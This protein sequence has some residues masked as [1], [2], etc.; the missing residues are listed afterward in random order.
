MFSCAEAVWHTSNFFACHAMLFPNV[1]I[2][3]TVFFLPLQNSFQP[4]LLPGPQHKSACYDHFTC[5]WVDSKVAISLISNLMASSLLLASMTSLIFQMFIRC[6]K[7]W[8]LTILNMIVL[9]QVCRLNKF[10]AFVHYKIVQLFLLNWHQNQWTA[11]LIL[12]LLIN[13][14]AK[15]CVT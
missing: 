4:T 14:K 5:S 9:S 2:K 3:L 6:Q 7:S 8:C 10:V 11:K 1:S 13:T 15:I 12:R